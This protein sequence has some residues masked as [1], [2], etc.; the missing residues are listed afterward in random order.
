MVPD[1]RTLFLVIALLCAVQG[2]AMVIF[3]T[4]NRRIPGIGFWAAGNVLNAFTM[5]LLPLQGVSENRVLHTL[6]PNFCGVAAAAAYYAGCCRFTGRESWKGHCAAAFS[7]W[8]VPYL[9]FFFSG[10]NVLGRVVVSSLALIFFNGVPGILL[11]RE[12]REGMRFST[13]FTGLLFLL[14]TAVMA[15]RMVR[16]IVARP[17]VPIFDGST[18][19]WV[20][21]MVAA[22]FAYLRAFGTILMV[23]QRQTRE[24]EERH[25]AQR[26]AEEELAEARREAAEERALRQRQALVRDLHDGIGGMTAN[27]AM[28]AAL[29]REEEREAARQETLKQIQ[30][31]ALE[32]NRELRSLMNTLDKGELHW[33]DWL[34]ELRDYVLKATE[35]HGIR[36][37]WEVRGQAP[38]APIAEPA[39][40]IS[41]ARALKEAV[42]N[43]TR[44]SGASEGRIELDFHREHLS[45]L[46][47]DDGRGLPDTARRGRGLPNMTRRAEELGGSL[48]FSGDRGTTLRFTLPL[49]LEYRHAKHAAP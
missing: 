20:M 35:P 47:T 37:A 1:L 22:A 8:L 6:V 25:A 28:L 44:H 2:T 41:L 39:A 10:E 13:H 11:I 15:A 49:P 27:L 9:Y 19:H 4:L 42:H 21:F 31:I 24:L 32:G 3:W 48:A 33:A 40:A 5:A 29:G 26:G 16:T 12:K 14:F 36:L 18:A 45:I 34:A 7:L 30:A 43:M 46:V 23:N 38:E 17:D